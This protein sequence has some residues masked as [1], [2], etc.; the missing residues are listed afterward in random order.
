M[1]SE[2]R[3][4]GL[5]HLKPYESCFNWRVEKVVKEKTAAEKKHAMRNE[6]QRIYQKQYRALL[7]DA[8]RVNPE[9]NICK[10]DTTNSQRAAR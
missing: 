8:S 4:T 3:T 2:L 5:E 9:S 7:R 6:R 10:S 1:A